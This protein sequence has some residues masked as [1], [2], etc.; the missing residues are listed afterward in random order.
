[1]KIRIATAVFV[2]LSA[3]G[4]LYAGPRAQETAP[5]SRSVWDGVYTEEQANRGQVV[6][7]R[8]CSRCHAVD[9]SGV[10]EAPALSGGAFLANWD[11]LTVGDLSERVRI[12]MPP[13]A[14]GKLSRQQI[15]DVLGH[16]LSVNGFP[17]GKSELDPKTEVLKLIR[18][19]A[20]KPKANTP[21]N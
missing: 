1:M 12:S 11:G 16:L 8:E 15:V 4:A 5:A 20:T 9:L 19:E 21:S 14:K 10:D 17:A 3:I 18:I 13:N 7:A 2:G 6:Y